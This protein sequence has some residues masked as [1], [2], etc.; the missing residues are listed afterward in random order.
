MTD[1]DFSKW[2]LADIVPEREERFITRKLTDEEILNE[3]A[4]HEASHFVFNCMVYRLG[5]DFLAPRGIEICSEKHNGR[6]FGFSP[7]LTESE[8]QRE[9][10]LK[11]WYTGNI[12]R[13]IGRMLGTIAGYTSYQIFIE[14][15]PYFVAVVDDNQ[16]E[17]KYFKLL[18]APVRPYNSD[19]TRF[20]E[21]IEYIHTG[22]EFEGIK[23]FFYN[24]A[25]K[26]MQI[27]AVNDSIRFIRNYLVERDCQFVE[28]KELARLRRE[29]IRLTNKIP[30][31]EVL[32][33][34]EIESALM[35]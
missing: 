8:L 23:E 19:F 34:I 32:E 24:E 30:I 13:L 29:V 33:K 17:V 15:S 10:I 26:L 20:R 27:Q 7:N 18:T 5:L 14:D 31:L 4:F 28:G 2:D 25:K 35:K 16:R 6:V 21:Y 22:Y 12:N 11:D 9:S 3:L 1:F